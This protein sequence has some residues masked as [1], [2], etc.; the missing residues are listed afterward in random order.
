LHVFAT[1][2]GPTPLDYRRATGH[3]DH[4]NRNA[5]TPEKEPLKGR[6]KRSPSPQTTSAIG[7]AKDDMKIVA[8]VEKIGTTEG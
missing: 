2:S 8:L 5:R 4:W 6:R 3:P 1:A 7:E